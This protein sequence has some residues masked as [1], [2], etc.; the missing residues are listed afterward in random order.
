MRYFIPKSAAV[1]WYETKYDDCTVHATGNP[2]RSQEGSGRSAVISQFFAD[3]KRLGDISKEA[4][5]AGFDPA[6]AVDCAFKQHTSKNNAWEVRPPEGKTLEEIK[7]VRKEREMTPEQKAKKEAKEAERAEQQRLREEAKAARQA[8]K[9]RK[10][11]ED[12]EARRKA[13]E[14]AAAA[15]AAA[16]QAE[17]GAE[18]APAKKGKGKGKAANAGPTAGETMPV[19]QGEVQPEANA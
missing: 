17:G 16:R 2:Y 3:G 8:E 7:A 5:A 18:A 4:A 6:F 15:A 13:R 19:D 10:A 9:E 11:A 1:D 12:K 14:E